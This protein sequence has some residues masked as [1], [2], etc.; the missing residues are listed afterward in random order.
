MRVGLE[1]GDF[2]I[3]R[4]VGFR[5]QLADVNFSQGMLQALAERLSLAPPADKVS[6]KNSCVVAQG[7]S[8]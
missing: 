3:K 4:A 5:V 2:N 8:A 1:L 7:L 6:G